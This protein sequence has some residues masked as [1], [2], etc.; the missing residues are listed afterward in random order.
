[1]VPVEVE[2]R[3]CLITGCHK[4]WIKLPPSHTA[5]S[6]TGA[7]PSCASKNLSRPEPWPLR[8][9]VPAH[10]CLE[11]GAH[12]TFEVW[13]KDSTSPN[14]CSGAAVLRMSQIQTLSSSPRLA[15]KRPLG[16]KATHVTSPE[17]A[18]RISASGLLVL[19]VP[20][21]LHSCT[22]PSCAPPAMRSPSGSHEHAVA[23]HRTPR[24]LFTL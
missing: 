24:P 20:R 12:A 13:N 18:S 14:A 9:L 7:P 21:G 11:S 15:S 2:Q 16:A 1:M 22:E 17:C 3:T 6:A 19:P 23:E 8:T 10:T 5:R 4:T